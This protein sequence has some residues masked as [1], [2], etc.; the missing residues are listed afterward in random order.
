M[1]LKQ[2]DST[3]TA[4]QLN[5]MNT[6]LWR[7]IAAIAD[8]EPLMRRLARYAKKLVKEKEDSTLMTKEEYF[9]ML[10]EAEK[11][12]YKRFGNVEELDRYIRGL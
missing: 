8:S 5:A 3:M 11:G 1:H 6:E 7:S 12:P 2:N 9:A 4:V 10:D